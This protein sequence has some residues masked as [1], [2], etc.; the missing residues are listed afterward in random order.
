MVTLSPDCVAFGKTSLPCDP[1]RG[2]ERWRG[3]VE[4]LKNLPVRAFANVTV[5]LSNH[6]V[7]YALI[8]WSTGLASGAEEN[9]YV[10]HHFAKIHGEAAK[11]WS[12]RASASEAGKPRLAS[13]VDEALLDAVRTCFPLS[14][15]ARLNSVQPLLMQRF[16]LCRKAIPASGAWLVI[17]EHGRACVA[18]HSGACWERV[19]S[20]RGAWRTLLD[21]A[22]YQAGGGAL[23]V[24]DVVF[25]D[26]APTP[27]DEGSWRFRGMSA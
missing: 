4:V 1:E 9:A 8:P 17:A 27:R 11:A 2:D 15:R 14:G 7:R 18:L 22:V 24:P 6:F 20:A 26:G 5:V 21:R 19:Q 10:R 13:A 12:V 23:A 3:A 25:L 16:N